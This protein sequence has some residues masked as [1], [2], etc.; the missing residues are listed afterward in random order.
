MRNN[1]TLGY[2]GDKAE[3]YVDYDYTA[4]RKWDLENA[5]IE[6]SPSY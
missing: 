6:L 5:G 1:P 3:R 4:A 2:H